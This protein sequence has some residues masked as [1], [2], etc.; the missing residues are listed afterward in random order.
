[1]H[2]AQTRHKNVKGLSFSTRVF[3]QYTSVYCCIIFKWYFVSYSIYTVH[4]VVYSL[5]S[6]YSIESQVTRLWMSSWQLCEGD[7]SWPS[8]RY[9]QRLVEGLREITINLSYYTDRLPEYDEC[10]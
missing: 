1:M 9:T 10:C 5:H 3:T 6:T 4:T 8:L 7:L 2:V